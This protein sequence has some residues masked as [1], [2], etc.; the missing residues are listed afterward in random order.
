MLF[1]I[2]L[3]VRDNN[4]SCELKKPY[5]ESKVKQMKLLPLKSWF[6]LNSVYPQR[7][8]L[9]FSVLFPQLHIDIH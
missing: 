9:S 1:F 4:A 3:Q 7:S 8:L 6:K 5:W 2:F